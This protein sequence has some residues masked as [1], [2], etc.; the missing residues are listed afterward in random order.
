MNTGRLA[1]FFQGSERV[2][3]KAGGRNRIFNLF[4][5]IKTDLNHTVVT[6]SLAKSPQAD[7]S[8]ATGLTG[9]SRQHAAV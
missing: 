8:C 5:A 6:V 1:L 9:G 7:R 3:R 4:C 2:E